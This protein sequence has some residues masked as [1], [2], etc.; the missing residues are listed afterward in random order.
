[1]GYLPKHLREWHPE[2][3]ASTDELAPGPV[4]ALAA[5]LDLPE[6]VALRGDLL[7]PMWHWLYFLDWPRRKDLGDDGHPLHGHF[8]PPIPDRRRMVAGGRMTIHSPL[9]LGRPAERS[10][11]LGDVQI[12][13]GRT[14]ELAFVT[15][16]HEF[17]QDS[18]LCLVEEHDVVYRSGQATPEAQAP[19]RPPRVEVMSEDQRPAKWRLEVRPDSALLFRFSALT[20]NAHRI[21]YDLAYSR[22]VEGYKELVVHGPLL[23]LLMLELPRR[24]SGDRQ[25]ASLSYRFRSPVFVDTSFRALATAEDDD[26][27]SLRIATAGN[28]RHATANIVF[29]P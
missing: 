22:D 25:V 10:S 9:V 16:R 13:Q 23:A 1:M 12:K 3:I 24:H 19:D 28:A 29:A 26:R 6:S 15:V 20:A 14:G 7:P 4:A 21:H 17:S 8:L 5:T 27:L 11:S 18:E 2:P